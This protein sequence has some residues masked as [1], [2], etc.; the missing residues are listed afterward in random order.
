MRSMPDRLVFYGIYCLVTCI[1]IAGGAV[2]CPAEEPAD[3][4]REAEPAGRQDVQIVLYNDTTAA[5]HLTFS[6][7][8]RVT[9]E[10]WLNPGLLAVHVIKLPGTPEKEY[11]VTAIVRAEPKNL[12]FETKYAVHIGS[13]HALLWYLPGDKKFRWSE[14][15]EEFGFQ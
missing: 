12:K 1:I 14:S 10:Q 13:K 15:P 11:R 6:L 4:S 7:E 9:V 3:S 8:G 2:S 5:V